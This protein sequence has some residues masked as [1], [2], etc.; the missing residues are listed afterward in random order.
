MIAKPGSTALQMATTLNLLQESD[1]GALEG[2]VDKAIEAMPEKVKEYKNG[3]KN[4]LGLFAGE[5]KKLSKGKADMQIVTKLL[6]EKL[7]N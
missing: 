2:W 1:T 3:K 5:V 6:S 4:L 7:N